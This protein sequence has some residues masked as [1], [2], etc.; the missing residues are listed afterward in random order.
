MQHGLAH[1][2]DL[3][4][5][6]PLAILPKKAAVISAVL[7]G[8][9]GIDGDVSAFVRSVSGPPMANR[10]PAKSGSAGYAKGRGVAVISVIG[11]LVPRAGYL[12]AESGLLS[13]ERLKAQVLAADRDPEVTAIV[14]DLH[15]P[16]GS[17]AGCFEAADVIHEVSRR[18]PVVAVANTMACSAGYAIAA[19]ANK[20][21]V[22]PSSLV[23]SIGVI[24]LHLDRS[25]QIEA[26]G[27]TPTIIKAGD[28]KA[29]GNETQPLSDDDLEEIQGEVDAFMNLFVA[30]VARHRPQLA[31]K[32]IRDTE[33]RTYMGADAVSV[34]L[35][36]EI[37]TIEKVVSSLS[38]LHP[39]T[40]TKYDRLELMWGKVTADAERLQDAHAAGARVGMAAALAGRKL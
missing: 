24:C 35:A 30:G 9:A 13:Y 3:A 6:V 23:G 25:R 8:R 20:I 21:V 38:K 15:T 34:G 7:G 2:A 17:A 32:A 14:L 27:I 19:A 28:R 40:S 39:V 1:L 29:V 26:Q 16:G 11:T 5:N 37:G 22:S 31:E 10:T 18:R 33:A 12:E 4:L 36:D